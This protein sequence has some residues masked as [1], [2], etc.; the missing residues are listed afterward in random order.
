MTKSL[1]VPVYAIGGIKPEHLPDL[2]QTGVAGVAIMSTLFGNANP[3]NAVKSY[4]EAY[5]VTKG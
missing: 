3:I 5:H 4:K 1:E 2:Q